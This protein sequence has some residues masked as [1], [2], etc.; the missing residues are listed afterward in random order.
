MKKQ[1]SRPVRAEPVRTCIGCR[2]SGE[3]SA[4]VRLAWDDGV[5]VVSRTA[6]GR[7]A[8]IHADEDCCTAAARKR[9]LARAFRIPGGDVGAVDLFELLTS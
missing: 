6:H 1:Q 5:V 4:L 9:A 7:G 2:Q 3:Q 8:W